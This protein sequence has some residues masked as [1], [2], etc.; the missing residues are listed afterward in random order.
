MRRDKYTDHERALARRLLLI[1]ALLW[2]YLLAWTLL[3][4]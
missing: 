1:V 3:I 2:A 4:S